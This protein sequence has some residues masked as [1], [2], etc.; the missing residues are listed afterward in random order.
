MH[1][2]VIDN[3]NPTLVS[4]YNS[5]ECLIRV[6]LVSNPYQSNLTKANLKAS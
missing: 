5:R 4:I 3:M 1:L 2:R 6:K